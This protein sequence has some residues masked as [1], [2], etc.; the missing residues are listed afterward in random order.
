LEERK[1]ENGKLMKK[2]NKGKNEM[3]KVT[4]ERHGVAPIACCQ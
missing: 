1:E 3:K 4:E 2:V